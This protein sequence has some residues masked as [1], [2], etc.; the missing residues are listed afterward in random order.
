MLV[1]VYITI[2]VQN[3]FKINLYIIV[4]NFMAHSCIAIVH[5]HRLKAV[6]QQNLLSQVQINSRLINHTDLS[7]VIP[8]AYV[9]NCTISRRLKK[10][11]GTHIL[12]TTKWATNDKEVISDLWLITVTKCFSVTTSHWELSTRLHWFL[13]KFIRGTIGQSLFF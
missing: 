11:V 10:T 9:H 13:S 5:Q 7:S 4:L 2:I 6:R 8:K 12:C 3:T 1:L